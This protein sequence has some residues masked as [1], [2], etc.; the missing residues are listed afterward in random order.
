MPCVIHF[1]MLLTLRLNLLI[2]T[3]K[4]RSY[5]EQKTVGEVVVSTLR[6]LFRESMIPWQI[7]QDRFKFFV[8]YF[9]KI[10][11]FNYYRLRFLEE[12]HRKRKIGKWSDILSTRITV[13]LSVWLELVTMWSVQ[14]SGC[15]TCL[16]EPVPLSGA[17]TIAPPPCWTLWHS[18][19][20]HPAL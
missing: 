3:G 5:K 1:S 15:D 14:T 4:E 12:L 9:R 10:M 6:I 7:L 17:L 2:W 20:H 16:A 19:P 8:V 13:L 11:R 18:D